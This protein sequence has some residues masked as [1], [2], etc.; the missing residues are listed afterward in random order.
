MDPADIRQTIRG[1]LLS[2]VLPGEEPGNLS[3]D[4][5]LRDAGVLDSVSTVQ[6]VDLLE[7]R[8]GV[9]VGVDEASIGN[10]ATINRLVEY[11][12][13]LVSADVG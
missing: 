2:E 10:F 13:G 4:L 11:I 7:N 6:L 9:E 8:F 5:N 3:D 1:W 12:S